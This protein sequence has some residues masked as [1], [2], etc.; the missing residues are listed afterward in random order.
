[1]QGR[2]VSSREAWTCSKEA[3]A[4]LENL[5]CRCLETWPEWYERG[6]HLVEIT[7]SSHRGWRRTGG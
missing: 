4:R 2:R 1:M 6:D 7:G 3:D 5:G